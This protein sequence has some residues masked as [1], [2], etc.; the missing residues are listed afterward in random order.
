MSHFDVSMSF[1]SKSE[2]ETVKE[3]IITNNKKA[4]ILDNILPFLQ[5]ELTAKQIE[6]LKVIAD[7]L[8]LKIL[9]HLSES[10]GDSKN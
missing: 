5:K 2:A 7:P 4:E 9:E 6:T 1:F 8:S 3:L 10:K